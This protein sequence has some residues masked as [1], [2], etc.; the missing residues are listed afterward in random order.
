MSSSDTALAFHDSARQEIIMRI[1]LRDNVLLFYLAVVGAIFGVALGTTVKLEVLLTIPFIAVGSAIMVAQHHEVIGAL[2]YFISHELYHHLCSLTP[3]ESTPQWDRSEAFR[4]HI[5]RAILYRVWGQSI[6]LSIPCIASLGC[7]YR[8][9][10]ASPFPYGPL[11]WFATL[12]TAIIFYI[13]YSA[14]KWRKDLY[15]KYKW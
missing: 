2:G 5:K 15:A 11:W 3:S 1:R 14:H 8:H 9:A 7:N 10:I 12:C 4:D 13:I 6:M